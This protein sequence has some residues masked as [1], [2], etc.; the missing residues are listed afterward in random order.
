MSAFPFH[1]KL[2]APGMRRSDGNMAPNTF[3][4]FKEEVVE[5]HALW[6]THSG[7]IVTEDEI[8]PQMI[9]HITWLKHDYHKEPQKNVEY[10]PKN[11]TTVYSSELTHYTAVRAT[12]WLPDGRKVTRD[13][14]NEDG[15]AEGPSK[16][17]ATG[18][19]F[20]KLAPSEEQ[21][22]GAFRGSP[23]S[24]TKFFRCP[25][26]REEQVVGLTVCLGCAG[27]TEIQYAKWQSEA[28]PAGT[29]RS[30]AQGKHIKTVVV[31]KMKAAEKAMGACGNLDEGEEATAVTQ[32]PKP[33]ELKI[34]IGKSGAGFKEEKARF[35]DWYRRVRQ[36]AKRWDE[37]DREEGKEGV[38]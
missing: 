9:S 30:R 31:P 21:V 29:P 17:P 26:C 36:A 32:R 28:P 6:L 27:E 23:V 12:G 20:T 35:S 5:N 4:Y 14:K 1:D 8:S 24:K 19:N 33:E 22:L 37:A 3:I 15:I 16:G 10:G 7:A 11:E 18:P 38:E 25:F 13:I 2:H 34:S